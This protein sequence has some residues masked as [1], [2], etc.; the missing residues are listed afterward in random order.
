VD[1]NRGFVIK[2]VVAATY[3]AMII[4]NAL[5]NAIPINGVT[6]GGVSNSYP[7]LFAPASITF[8]IWGLIYIL[9]AGYT[10]YQ[11]GLFQADRGAAREE[12]F[13]SVGILFAISSVA[14]SLWIFAW[15][16]DAIWLSLLFMIVI[17]VCLIMIANRLREEEFST[18]EKIFIR[19]PFSIYFGWITVATIANV[20][21][22]LVSIGWGGRLGAGDQIWMVIILLV[23]A[24]IGIAR[25]RYDMDIAYGLVALWAYAGILNKHISPNEFAGQYPAVIIFAIVSIILLVLA[26]VLFFYPGLRKVA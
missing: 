4:V 21:T 20:T 16:Y 22:F 25:M 17:L 2:V 6:T 3:L 12:L 13:Q 9:L 8:S 14:N 10:F 19:L 24:A 15:H 7:D 23:G 11:F 18:Q 5:A 26:K 1:K